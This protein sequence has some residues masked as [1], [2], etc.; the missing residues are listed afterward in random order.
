MF[1]MDSDFVNNK[2]VYFELN[3]EFLLCV[4]IFLYDILSLL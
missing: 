2:V 3:I 4:L 1:F